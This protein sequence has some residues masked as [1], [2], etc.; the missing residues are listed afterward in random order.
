VRE[1][2]KHLTGES[3]VY[4]LGQVS[5]RAVQLLLVPVLTRALARD[6]YGVAD[7]VL[8]YSQFAVLVLVFG[9]DAAL[10][11]FFY[12]EPDRQARRRMVASSLAFRVL[13]ALAAAALLAWLAE[14]LS[15]RLVGSPAY[16]KYVWIGAATLPFSLL[17]L[18][19]NDVLRVTF[20]PWKF[21]ALNLVQT[22]AITAVSLWLVLD[23]GLGV[24][25]VL[26]GKLAGDTLCAGLGLLLIRPSLAPRVDRGVLSRM[27]RYG[28]P[29]V[30]ASIAY[31]VVSSADRYFLQRTRGLAE[32]GVYAVAVK[33][34]AVVMMGVSAFSLAFFPF[35]H[36]RSGSPEAPRLYARAMA[37][38]VACASLVALLVGSFAPEALTLLA[39]PAY[40]EAALPAL[41]LTFAAVAYGAYYVSCLGI[42]L[43]LRTPLL[44][45]TALAA[46]FVA[47][48]AN[49]VLTP[50][51][52]MLGAAAATFVGNVGLAV[53]TYAAS[54]RVHPLPYRGLRL[55]LLFALGLG[56]AFFAQRLG[57]SGAVGWAL[58]LGAAVAFAAAAWKLEVWRDRGAVRPIETRGT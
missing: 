16:R 10:V 25:G 53:F 20:Q 31:G 41:V 29:L 55:A 19:A 46:A 21:I 32:V 39:P 13:A 28:F 5:G 56:L 37:L 23:R 44:G 30:P 40:R 42:Q 24:A 11:R 17:V 35:A 22:V 54:Q 9:M 43:S 48:A 58:K 14:P 6:V 4:G 45:W 7:L 36:A 18:F 50:R 34:F 51:L 33:F 15:Q 12:Q 3:L 8:A 27:L 38:Y 2:L 1:A 57:P 26:Y 52:G 49:L 47:V